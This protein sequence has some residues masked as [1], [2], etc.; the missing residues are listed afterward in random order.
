MPD[1]LRQAQLDTIIDGK[2]LTIENY[3][4]AQKTIKMA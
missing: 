3:I 1:Q 4:A 2:F